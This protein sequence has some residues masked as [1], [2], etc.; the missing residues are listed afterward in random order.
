MG[1][2]LLHHAFIKTASRA[3]APLLARKDPWGRLLS[4]A[5]ATAGRVGAAKRG[6][7]PWDS[8]EAPRGGVSGRD[9]GVKGVREGEHQ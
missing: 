6:D 5:P 9:G 1:D 7:E 2:V 4:A 8:D 3:E